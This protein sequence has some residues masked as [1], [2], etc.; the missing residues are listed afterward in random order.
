MAGVFVAQFCCANS[1]AQP[2][3]MPGEP[4]GIPSVESWTVEPA[5]TVLTESLYL[6]GETNDGWKAFRPGANLARNALAL[7]NAVLDL[8]CRGPMS[9]VDGRV[10]VYR[11]QYLG[12]LWHSAGPSSGLWGRLPVLEMVLVKPGRPCIYGGCTYGLEQQTPEMLL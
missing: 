5:V 10:V 1:G 3:F 6:R 9:Q 8:R 2:G 4:M 12:Y 7:P 11:I